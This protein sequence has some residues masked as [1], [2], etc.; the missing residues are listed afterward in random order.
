MLINK[1]LRKK[2]LVKLCI[3]LFLFFGISTGLTSQNVSNAKN[4]QRIAAM[5]NDDIITT[6]DLEAR[7]KLVI[8][9]AALTD[10]QTIRKR[11]LNQVLRSL[12]DER[13]QLQETKRLNISVSRRDIRRAK[14]VIEKENKIQKGGLAKILKNNRVPVEAIEDQIRAT[15]AW[16]K[17]IRRRLQ[18]RINISEDE[19]EEAL[20]KIRSQT[21]KIEYRLSEILLA[22]DNP[23]EEK[24]VRNSA[25]RLIKQA[26]KGVRFSAIAR[27]FSRSA[28]AAVGGDV[29]WIHE[30][31]IDMNTRNVLKGLTIGEISQPIKTIE[32]YR[33]IFLVNKRMIGQNKLT[34]TRV[35]L[36]QIFLPL[37]A[38]ATRKEFQ[39]R[40]KLL[41][42]VKANAGDCADFEKLALE[43]GSTR[44]ATLGTLNVKNLSP[45]IRET[46]K[47]IPVGKISDPLRTT[48]GVILLMVCNKYGG[49]PIYNA[50][51]RDLIAERLMQKRLRL[52]TRRYMHD[53]RLS[54][55]IDIR[56]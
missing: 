16:S 14:S 50:P 34:P 45:L 5:V 23:E 39:N 9:S 12:I 6:Y 21:G 31:D 33:I 7:I 53:L 3:S 48:T 10:S 28:T 19:I 27:Q 25:Q 2:L 43:I 8:F 32:G 11:I 41:K 40:F 26:K 22:V 1:F 47:K 49:K 54:A 30:T 20:Q 52:M 18:P 51:K 55:V 15:I 4:L 13:L 44:P 56:L 24:L 46:V 38:Q 37:E 42:T 29:G 35:D 36:R 17:L